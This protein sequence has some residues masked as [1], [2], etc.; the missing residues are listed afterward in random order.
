MRRQEPAGQA[1]KGKFHMF[2]ATRFRL[3]AALFA[4]AGV[5]ASIDARAQ[6]SFNSSGVPGTGLSNPTSLEFGPDERLYVSQQN[7]IIRAYTLQRNAPADYT[8]LDTEVILEIQAGIQNHD[9]DGDAN[10]AED[11][12]QITGLMTA[13]T[14]ANPVLYVTSSDPRIAVGN[15]TGL[16]TNSGVISR[17]TCVGGISG[18]QCAGWE[19]VD[20]VR[21]LPRSEENHSTNGI[22]LDPVNNIL[23]VMSGGHANKG[24][25]G[26]NFAGTPEYYLSAAMLAVDLDA[27]AAI[28]AA[29]GGPFVDARNGAQYVYDLV[30]LDDPT[31]PN[32]NVGDLGY[33]YGDA[34]NPNFGLTIDVGD[35]FGG[36]N[37]LNQAIPIPG[38]PVQIHSPGYRNAYDVVFTESGRI[39][40]WDNGPNTG[41]GG[42]PLIFQS[43]DTPKGIGPF[44]EAAGDY[45][46]NGFNEDGSNGHGD[47]LHDATAPGYYGGHPTPIRAFP[48]LAGVV[49]YV[50]VTNGDWQQTGPVYDFLA[51]LPAGLGL[52]AADFPNNPV[53]CDYQANDG[54]KYLEQ[55]AASTNG[56]AEYTATNFLGEMQGDLLAAS[57]NGNV[58]RC[59]PS[60]ASALV[61]LPGSGAGLTN[62][63][64]EV[65]FSG[66]GSQPL[67]VTTQGDVD[68]FAGTVWAATYGANSITV[69]EPNDFLD[70]D[71]SVPTE[72]S[73]GDG[74]SNGDEA[75]NGTNPCSGGSQPDDNDGDF[76]SD[77]NDPDDDNDGI[78]DV[79]DPFAVDPNDGLGTALPIAYSLFNNDPGTGLFGLGFTGLMLDVGGSATWLDLFDPEQ[80]AA[81]G[82]AGLLT[83]ENVTVGDAFQ[84]TNSQENAFL[85]GID[86]D[87]DTPPFTVHSRVLQPFF[88][89]GGSPNAPADFQSFG[90][91]IGTGDQDDYLKMVIN[92]GVQV[93]TEI[94]GS[95]GDV[96]GST[97]AV[98]NLLNAPSVDLYLSVDPQALTVQPR[99]SLNEGGTITD[100]GGPIPIPA[101]WLSNSDG[102]GLAVGVIS[103]ANGATPFE[104]TWDFINVTEN[105][106]DAQARV[107]VTPGGG[108]NAS[109]F[110]AG[111]FSI[112]NLSTTADITGVTIDLRTAILP[113]L[114]FDPTDGTPAG[115]PVDKCLEPSSG[116]SDTGYVAPGDLCVDPFSVPNDDGFSVAT[117]AFGDFN[118]GETFTFAVDID[119]TSIKG[120][121]APGPGESGSVSGLELTGARVTVEFDDGSSVSRAADL[122]RVAG[123]DGGSENTVRNAL[124]VQPSISVDDVTLANPADLPPQFQTATVGAAAQ[125]VRVQGPVGATVRLL[126]LETTLFEGV[127]GGFDV[128]AF[129][130]NS[131][132]AVSEFTGTIPGPG[133]L[134]FPVTLAPVDAQSANP[135]ATATTNTIVAVLEDGSDGATGTVSDVVVLS[136]DPAL[137]PTSLYRVN[138]GGPLVAATDGG[139]DW[140]ADTG[141]ANSQYLADAGSNNTS[142]FA[143]TARDAGLPAYVPD[144][145]FA[146]ERWD[147]AGGTEMQW[148]FPVTPGDSYLVRLYIMNG[149]TGT[150]QPGERVFD[151]TI[152]GAVPPTFDDVD[153][154]ATWGDQT[155]GMLEHQFTAA[156]ATLDIDFLHDVI[157]NPLVN[158]IEVLQVGAGSGP[159][160]VPP[161]I[162]PIAN[163]TSAEGENVDFTIFASDSDGPDNLTFGATGLPPGLSLVDPTNGLVSGVIAAGAAAGS[164]YTVTVTADDGADTSQQTFDWIVTG[165]V[166]EP[167]TVLYRVNNGGP[168][169]A[170]T[171]AST[172]PGAR[173][174]RR[175][176]RAASAATPRKARRHPFSFPVRATTC[177]ERRPPST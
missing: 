52:T 14:A 25:P 74:F 63:L 46:T 56:L 41:W 20:I 170:A 87:V 156:D 92:G 144:A 171:D 152:E 165:T 155:G 34:D 119:P 19:R 173:T 83:V 147:D 32:L 40:T 48:G 162:D 116:A 149:F 26:N 107:T 94:G 21:G 93:A 72:D 137:T 8:I 98:A 145:V 125:T 39:Y 29:N 111:S 12:R 82:A 88:G 75:D 148:A 100:L 140:T 5:F 23:Y 150:D 102:Q 57:F 161:V 128:D 104:A 67:D 142:S 86:V 80:L 3:L 154:T 68:V 22:D 117:L 79:S 177:S 10:N 167:G 55:A 169:V 65:L 78:P 60:G 136:Y 126:V 1:H 123:S 54:A 127:S 49:N 138:A 121:A 99:V 141:A 64:C 130:A 135:A 24:A 131:V 160:N 71:P 172:H 122:F 17:L 81:G 31:R 163:Q 96:P 110:G 30:T 134:A 139:P 90:I 9:D 77:L 89:V 85:F 158:A 91:F 124:P 66:F 2:E 168:E 6:I 115:D 42:Q 44:D 95:F 143:L 105:P 106:S 113:D 58:Y 15:D 175:P 73:D 174:R 38:G 47:P 97:F 61:N 129:E 4:V 59:K 101:G 84:A 176:D 118:P 109:T 157:E 120:E 133:G 13:G 153:P 37:G 36:N 151:I 27:I 33:P 108:L 103:T 50:E 7:G 166:S 146:T 43:D 35:P 112:E 164:P 62:N 69:F 70:C 18:N 132:T 11:T 114:V 53:E 159:V 51:L 45:C 16:D 76:L 28:E